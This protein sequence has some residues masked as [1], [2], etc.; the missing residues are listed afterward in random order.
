MELKEKLKDL[1][2]A[3]GVIGSVVAKELNVTTSA[4]SNYE[5]GIRLPTYDVLIKI[6]KYF[7]VSTDYLLGLEDESGAKVQ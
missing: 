4:Y 6:A 7:D 3:K 1:R 5:Q 2:K